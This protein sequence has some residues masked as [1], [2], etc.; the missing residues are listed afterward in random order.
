[1]AGASVAG[2]AIGIGHE[3]DKQKEL[4]NTAASKTL[5]T[6]GH[7]ADYVVDSM[8]VNKKEKLAVD[9]AKLAHGDYNKAS[10]EL[11]AFKE[12]K[13]SRY[14]D[15][16][17]KGKFMSKKDKEAEIIKRQHDVDRLK[18][19]ADETDVN[20]QAIT[21]Q[22]VAL[23]QRFKMLNIE[24]KYNKDTYGKYGYEDQQPLMNKLFS[25]NKDKKNEEVKKEAK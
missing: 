13:H 11:K 14:S 5:E 21:A 9:Q 23:G 6:Q 19:A 15:G 12:E 10:N 4:K 20:L 22:R 18:I 3:M 16:E 7:I 1:M 8:T 17:K 24:N 25:D 2:A